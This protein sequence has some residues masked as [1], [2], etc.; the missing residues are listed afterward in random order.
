MAKACV[1]T[2]LHFHRHKDR[3]DRL[4]HCVEVLHWV[5][6]VAADYKCN[7]IFFLGDL[8]H[9]RDKIDLLNYLKCFEV[10]M[11]HMIEDAA[12]RDMY[13]LVGNHDMYHQKTW[14]VNSVKP[15]SAIP[16]VHIINKPCQM[17]FGKCM[18]DWLPYTA[19]PVQDLAEL[20]KT[21]GGA[22]DLLLGHVA[23]HGAKLN[24][25]YGTKADVIVEYDND[26]VPVDIGVFQD[27]KAVKLGHYHGAQV[28]G[29]IEYIGS[30]LQL[31]FGEAFQQKHI[32]I[33]D[34]EDLSQEYVINDFSPKHLIVSPQDIEN[35]SYDLDNSFV[36]LAVDHLTNKQVVDI[37]KSVLDKYKLLSFDTKPKERTIEEDMVVMEGAKS[38]LKDTAKMLENY[39]KE[40]GVPDGLKEDKLKKIGNRC[41]E[42]RQT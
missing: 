27:W 38:I 16:R 29:N 32:V 35:E 42:K 25:F 18:V 37:Q 33:L 13:L 34:L 21:T 20:K 39:V 23:V 26:M 11:K 24:T 7:Y 14:D 10:F 22:G 17:N 1:F 9:E 36:R 28:M 30:P 3:V 40:R 8:L 2:D 41:L 5:F 6:R 4:L 31:T 12:D 19:N 15:F